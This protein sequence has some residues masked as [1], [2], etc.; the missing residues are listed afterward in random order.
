MGVRPSPALSTSHVDHSQTQATTDPPSP[1]DSL[2]KL[3]VVLQNE[4]NKIDKSTLMSHAQEIQE[5]NTME[6]LL[7]LCRLDD[8]R[9]TEIDFDQF[10]RLFVPP[11]T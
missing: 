6:R 2:R 10:V 4:N 11:P 3:F 8:A 9:V 1:E 7:Q 5:G